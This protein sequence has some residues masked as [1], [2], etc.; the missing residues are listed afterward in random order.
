MK[1]DDPEFVDPALK[2]AV[3]RTCCGERCPAALRTRIENLLHEESTHRSRNWKPWLIGPLAAA[4]LILLAIGVWTRLYQASPPPTQLAALPASLQADLIQRHDH[5]CKVKNH[6]GL[7]V[8]IDNDSAIASAMRHR[9]SHAVLMDRPS[10]PG[11]TFRGASICPVGS[12]PSG[13]LVFVK[14]P[15]ALSVFSLPASCDPC[16]QNGNQCEMT[17][18]GHLIVA[19][20]K[21][22]ALF[23]LVGSGPQGTISMDEL[24]K[25][26]DKM[27]PDVVAARPVETRPAFAEL[28]Y[29]LDK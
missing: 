19:F 3:K 27:K 21:D 13:H 18:D 17:T 24:N 11:W 1:A 28:I 15:D 23:C 14:G 9:L 12:I 29:P 25:M 8:R 22:G 16:L 20:A 6:Q 7:P 10:E 4:A 26:R 2:S 5:C